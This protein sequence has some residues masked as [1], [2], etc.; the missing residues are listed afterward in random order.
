MVL[1]S[2]EI[3]RIVRLPVLLFGLIAIE[4]V[5]Y[6]SLKRYGGGID[7]IPTVAWEEFPEIDQGLLLFLSRCQ[8]RRD[9]P[10]LSRT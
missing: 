8:R 5:S 10:A 2:E 1:S 3:R 9:V 7:G 6:A 4:I